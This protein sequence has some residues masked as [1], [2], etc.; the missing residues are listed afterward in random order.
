MLVHLK[1]RI[2]DVIGG[3]GGG[4]IERAVVDLQG[5]GDTRQDFLLLIVQ[6]GFVLV[7]ANVGGILVE[8]GVDASSRWVSPLKLQM[9]LMRSSTDM[10]MT[11]RLSMGIS[12]HKCLA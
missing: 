7:D 3:V 5:I 9:H 11:S 4:L 1:Q 10:R 12:L 2:H 6:P 8:S